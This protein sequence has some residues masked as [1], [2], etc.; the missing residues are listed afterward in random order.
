MGKSPLFVKIFGDVVKRDEY[1]Q[2][3]KKFEKCFDLH[4][5]MFEQRRALPNMKFII[6]QGGQTCRCFAEHES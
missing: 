2:N 5:T 4:Q 6:K 1:L 3:M